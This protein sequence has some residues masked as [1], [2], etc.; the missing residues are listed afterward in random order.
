MP[1]DMTKAERD[2]L[3]RLARLRAKQAERE[4][5]AREKILLAEVQD[6]ATAE[7]EA[8][9]HLWA[10]AVAIAE[11][12]AAKANA[13]IQ[14]RCADLGIPPK[15]APRLELGWRS[16]SGEY[17][18]PRRRAELLK[19][20]QTRLTALTKTAKTAIQD[21]LLEVETDLIVGALESSEARAALASLPTV[22]HLMPKLN[23]EDLG[24]VHWQ[25]PEDIAA[26]LTTPMTTAQRRRRQILRAIEANPGASDR[27]IAKI[28]GVD[29]KTV[30]THRRDEGGEFLAIGGESPADE[31]GAE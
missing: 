23:L 8:R 16:R 5:E 2:Q 10:D 26:Q 1:G 11:E 12:A 4:A 13:Q 17:E 20:A 18:N 14:A 30:A 21:R 27:A 31:D 7:Y 6:Q 3:V 28:A 22:E 25:P 29:H 24:V 15:Q 19:L 9:D